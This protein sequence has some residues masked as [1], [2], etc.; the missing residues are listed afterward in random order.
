M[1]A[2]GPADLVVVNGLVHTEAAACYRQLLAADAANAD[3]LHL[4]GVI[5]NQQGEHERAVALIGE[6]LRH[7]PAAEHFHCNMGLALMGRGDLEGARRRLSLFLGQYWGGPSTYSDER[8][9]PRLRMRHFP[10]AIGV[11][12]RDHWLAHMRAALDALAP[13][14]EVRE[15]FDR[16]LEMAAESLR[17]QEEAR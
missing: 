3:A 13:A 5:A 15:A 1:N 2:N 10:F 8:G 16:Y 14:P 17:N 7:K 6:A 11:A 4:L 9:H 12:E